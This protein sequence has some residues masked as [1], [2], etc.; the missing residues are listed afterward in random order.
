MKNQ[1]MRRTAC[2]LLAVLLLGAG[3]AAA[4][5]KP[6]F[7]DVSESDWFY[8]P[9][10][11]LTSQGILQGYGD[12]TFRPGDTMTMAHFVKLL[13][14]P[15]VPSAYRARCLRPSGVSSSWR[16]IS[17]YISLP[18]TAQASSMS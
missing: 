15:M 14:A 13:L 2:L 17:Q 11:F 12:G 9:V 7:S 6:L 8:I 3:A 4:Q 10:K 16:V 1:L 5:E 18:E